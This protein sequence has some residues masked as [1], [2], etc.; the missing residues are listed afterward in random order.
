MVRGFQSAMDIDFQLH[1][2][3]GPGTT[4]CGLG[5]RVIDSNYVDGYQLTV[6]PNPRLDRLFSAFPPDLKLTD[7]LSVTIG[8]KVDHNDFTGFEFERS[9]QLAWAPPERQILWASEAQAIREPSPSDVS[10]DDNIATVPMGSTVA[11]VRAIG[12]PNIKAEEFRDLEAGY[13]AQANK[14]LALD[15]TAFA[16]LYRNLESSAAQAPYFAT[17]QGVR[18]LVLHELVV[19]GPGARTYCG[20]FFAHW[21][22]IDR[23]RISPGYSYFHIHTD[24]DSQTLVTPVATSPNHQFQVHSLLDLPHRLEC[25]NTH[26]FFGKLVVGN[27]PLYARVDSRLGWRA[28]EFVELSLVRQNLVTPRH[29][30]FSD[31]NYRTNRTLVERS[32]FLKVTWRFDLRK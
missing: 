16:C 12:N 4:L 19:N 23:W 13:R 22:L 1:V 9:A 6:I 10:V 8:S 31:G 26:G 11:I 29:V 14:R 20:E 5:A 21:N 3:L 32:V 28:G 2:A 24:G 7:S 17:H 30:E 25:D 18:Y 27:I 15:V